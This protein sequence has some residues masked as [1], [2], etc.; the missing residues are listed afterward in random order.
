MA[1]Q[2]NAKTSEDKNGG[3]GHNSAKIDDRIVETMPKFLRLEGLITAAKLKHIKPL[4]DELSSEWKK[5]S[6]DTGFPIKYMKASYNLQKLTDHARGLD[7]DTE[8]AAA[9]D[10]LLITFEAMSVGGHLDLFEDILRTKKEIAAANKKPDQVD[11]KTPE[12]IDGN[13]KPET[14]DK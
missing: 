11:V 3:P 7:D 12:N 6:A 8:R 5:L 4:T 9:L 1:E 14:G 10:A 2:M 13:T